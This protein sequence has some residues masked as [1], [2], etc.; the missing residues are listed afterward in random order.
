MKNLRRGHASVIVKAVSKQDV[1][2][3]MNITTK[4][5]LT[6][7]EYYTAWH[8]LKRHGSAIAPEKM[9]GATLILIGIT[10]WMFGGHALFVIGGIIT[11]L[12]TLI[13]VPLQRRA[14]FK[15]RWAK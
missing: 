8:F 4:F 13:G 3:G 9:A 15:R 2:A 10:I 12:T 7:H 11:G 5:S 1:E 6:W 14:E